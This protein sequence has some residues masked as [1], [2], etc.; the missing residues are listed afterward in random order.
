[1]HPLF[2]LILRDQ[3]PRLPAVIKHFHEARLAHFDGKV[4]VKGSNGLMAKMLRKLS[5]FPSPAAA[6]VDMVVKLIRT[7][8]QER[9]SRNFN[10]SQFSSTLTRINRTNLLREDFGLF[11]FC[12]SL[13][14]RNE[15]IVWQLES[16]SFA[17]IPMLEELIEVDAWEGATP[18]GNYC[19][20]FKV[21][22]PLVGVL[23]DYAGWLA[24]PAPRTTAAP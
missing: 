18:D 24:I 21:E 6:E 5:G 16:W 10:N 22:F 13:R 8:V 23:I 9:W 1:M 7:E 11:N 15:R 12:Y 14:V 19:F 4:E 20:A 3:Y 2:Q 17:G